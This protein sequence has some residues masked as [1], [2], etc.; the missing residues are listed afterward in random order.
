MHFNME[1][2]YTNHAEEEIKDRKIE[3]IWVEETIKSPDI[4]KH[5]RHKYYVIKKINGLS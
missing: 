4:T 5:D 2:K 1:I 3:K